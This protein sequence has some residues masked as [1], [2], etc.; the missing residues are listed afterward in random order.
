[1]RQLIAI[2]RFRP[3]ADILSALV[4]A[5]L[6]AGT[7]AALAVTAVRLG[8]SGFGWLVAAL[9]IAAAVLAP[10]MII[11]PR[12]DRAA[13]IAEAIGGLIAACVVIAALI[14]S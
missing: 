6:L 7:G 5:A 3:R 1:M 10:L 12:D 2:L 8:G 14:G 9:A 11:E 4:A 13:A